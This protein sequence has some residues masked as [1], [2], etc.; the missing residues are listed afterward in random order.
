MPRRG[1]PLTSLIHSLRQFP[2][3]M[4]SQANNGSRSPCHCR[5]SHWKSPITRAPSSCYQNNNEDRVIDKSGDC[6]PRE[7][8]ELQWENLSEDEKNVYLAHKTA[9][10]N[11]ENGYLDPVTGYMVFT[12]EFLSKRKTCC[13]N[14]CRH[15]PFGHENV[16]HS[17]RKKKFNSAF[18]V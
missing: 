9:C 2:G 7:R 8:G 16:P 3:V 17:Q 10:M 18:Y 13:G 5:K 4:S 1:V 12:E 6:R 14:G 15:C 11:G